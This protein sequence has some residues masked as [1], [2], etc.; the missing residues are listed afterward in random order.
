MKLNVNFIP[1]R[2]ERQREEPRDKKT[3]LKIVKFY[4]G[5]VTK[6]AKD[7]AG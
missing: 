3:K 5:V 4:P 6:V 2:C 7:R 1:E